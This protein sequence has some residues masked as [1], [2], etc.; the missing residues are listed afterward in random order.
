MEREGFGEIESALPAQA[1]LGLRLESEI[2]HFKRHNR[3]N[4]G[5]DDQYFHSH[6][7]IVCCNR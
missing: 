4:T 5:D 7:L 1:R 3:Y 2:K 6:V